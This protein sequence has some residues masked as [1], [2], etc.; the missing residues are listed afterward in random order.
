MDFCRCW[1]LA[2]KTPP[3]S[4]RHP[5]PDLDPGFERQTDE[6]TVVSFRLILS[7]LVPSPRSCLISSHLISSQPARHASHLIEGGE[8]Q[9]TWYKN[10]LPRACFDELA[11]GLAAFTL[12]TFRQY[13]GARWC[14][15][16]LW[17]AQPLLLSV[18]LL[19]FSAHSALLATALLRLDLSDFRRC[20]GR[21]VG[22]T[23]S[24]LFAVAH[25]PASV[26]CRVHRVI[27][28]SLAS[29]IFSCVPCE[30]DLVPLPLFGGVVSSLTVKHLLAR[31]VILRRR[32]YTDDRLDRR[33]EPLGPGPFDRLGY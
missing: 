23:L 6:L 8:N 9:E 32:C 33:A 16:W 24:A 14:H 15:C 1:L 11:S 17:T 21:F 13:Y 2:C 28:V 18:H 3:Q 27:A 22:R 19:A 7:R 30:P 26:G 10:L 25:Q 20:P 29:R 12:L 31:A 4:H 5:D